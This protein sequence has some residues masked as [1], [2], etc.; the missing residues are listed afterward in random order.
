MIISWHFNSFG[1]YF[2]LF[3]SKSRYFIMDFITNAK[4][5]Y[6]G[7]ICKQHNKLEQYKTSVL[8][9]TYGIFEFWKVGT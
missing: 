5:L 4:I 3:L 6:A 8:S 9:W 7:S 2:R 1:I